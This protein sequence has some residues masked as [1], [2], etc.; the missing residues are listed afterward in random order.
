MIL[1]YELKELERDNAPKTAKIP[2]DRPYLDT[3]KDAMSL[4][5]RAVTRAMDEVP[6][7]TWLSNPS[8][9]RAVVNASLNVAS[10]RN[11]GQGYEEGDKSK[12]DQVVGTYNIRPA[13]PDEVG[14][15]IEQISHQINQMDALVQNIDAKFNE[16]A[17]LA[18]SPQEFVALSKMGITTIDGIYAIDPGRFT[19]KDGDGRPMGYDPRNIIHGLQA[20][21]HFMND[22]AKAS[23]EGMKLYG[24]KAVEQL[25]RAMKDQP[26]APVPTANLSVNQEVAAPS[27][28]HQRIFGATMGMNMAQSSGLAQA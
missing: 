4:V 23:A 19:P 27:V 10:I 7:P 14:A 15:K 2:N 13:I 8:Q 5:Q 24:P 16:I 22:P 20:I 1:N 25:Q 12:L 17:Q 21:E 3:A 9:F 28:N 6:Q 26:L 18:K 11:L